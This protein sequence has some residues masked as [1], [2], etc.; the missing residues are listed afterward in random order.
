MY[1]FVP[2]YVMSCICLYLGHE[3][4]VYSV[5]WQP[6]RQGSETPSL[7]SASMDKTMVL[8]THDNESGLWMEQVSLP[9]CMALNLPQGT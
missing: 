4:W 7:L 5:R 1:L 9:C 2:T 6:L 3:D 8:W